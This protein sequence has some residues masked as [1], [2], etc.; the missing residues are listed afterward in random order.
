M[1]EIGDQPYYFI[2]NEAPGGTWGG[3]DS[4]KCPPDGTNNAALHMHC[5]YVLLA[6]LSI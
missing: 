6:T 3:Q 5:K 4:T 2:I 1:E